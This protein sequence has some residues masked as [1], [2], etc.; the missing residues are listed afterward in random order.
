MDFLINKGP[1]YPVELSYSKSIKQLGA[2]V[3]AS[4]PLS[5]IETN[6]VADIGNFVEVIEDGKSYFR[7]IITENTSTDKKLSITAYDCCYR[8]KKSKIAI[9]FDG[10][11]VSD[12]LMELW[13][14]CGVKS[15]HIPNMTTQIESV[16]Y[17]QSPADIAK[18]LV[19]IEEENNGGEYY[20]TSEEFD[21]VEIYELGQKLCPASL[22]VIM[23]PTKSATLD[24][25][26]NHVSILVSDG[27]GYTVTESARDWP[28]IQKYGMFLREYIN[29][30][31]DAS[32][33]VGVAQN[34]LSRL[35]LLLAEGNVTVKGDW[36]LTAVG[37]RIVINEPISGLVGVYVI[38]SVSHKLGDDFQ[39]T[40]GLKE[41][42]SEPSF[43]ST[44]A[45]STSESIKA[46]TASREIVERYE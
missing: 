13:R 7:G 17:A 9:Q 3:K 25:V 10:M 27:N 19:S 34:R 33:A 23:A 18:K 1:T 38:T 41:Y 15:R 43:K 28:S 42:Y 4:F 2:C 21:T 11:T 37:N 36:A 35:K 44:I 14:Y 20:I 8:L 26:K 5:D 29:V 16:H 32:S 6:I 45:A 31:S 30:S 40:L 12:A 24:G 46:L 22:S 39:T